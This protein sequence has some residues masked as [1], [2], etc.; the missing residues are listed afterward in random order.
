MKQIFIP[1]LLFLCWSLQAQEIQEAQ[2][3][4]VVQP[5]L[6]LQLWS[7]YTTDQQLFNADLQQL[8]AVDNRVNFLLQRTRLGAKGSYGSR[9]VYDLT[10]SLDFVGRDVLAGTFGAS[11]N[12]PSP[13][14]RI[15]NA[16]VQYKASPQ[17]EHLYITFGYQG[18]Q[19]FR[20]SITSP[21]SVSSFE[22]SFTQNY[23]RRHVVGTGPGRAVGM[24]IGGFFKGEGDQKIAFNYDVGIYNPRFT[25]LSGNSTGQ[26]Y[27]PLLTGRI[28]IHIGDPEYSKY[29]RGHKF[30]YRGKRNGV[31]LSLTGNRTG[32][33]NLW[34][35][36]ES[37]G[38]DVLAN[39]GPINIGG[40]WMQLVR[41]LEDTR[42]TAS[43]GF[44]R[45]SYH[46]P[47][48][49]T[50]VFEPVITYFFLAGATA[51]ADQEAAIALGTFSG[52]DNYIELTMN[53][54]MSPKARF[55]LSYTL[56]DGEAG[57]LDSS[58]V[59]NNFFQQGGAGAIE[60]GSYLGIG[61]LFN[62]FGK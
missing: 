59:N 24:N 54:Y 39:F 49:N 25:A 42:S 58:L 41:E 22:K 44:A 14:F 4:L 9:W 53:Y 28:G 26:Q 11:N 32:A 34:D 61:L 57:D 29:S 36:N 33:T 17:S 20:E 35:S 10:G 37:Y 62:V 16:L 55:S 6:A 43:A 15:W 47:L 1:I 27:S 18:P 8:E 21:F 30:N 60:R 19:M 50:K 48:K 7:T 12:G 13:L 40:E 45:I 56:R 38:I 5:I 46:M 23:S 3:K 52:R 31:T 2:E 51:Q